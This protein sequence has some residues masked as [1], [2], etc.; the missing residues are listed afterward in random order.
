MYGKEVVNLDLDHIEEMDE[1]TGME[2]CRKCRSDKG[3]LYNG[4][5]PKKGK[6]KLIAMVDEEFSTKGVEI[7]KRLARKYNWH[8]IQLFGVIAQIYE[9]TEEEHYGV[10]DE[11]LLM[12]LDGEIKQTRDLFR[13]FPMYK[14]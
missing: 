1:L 3:R 13:H 12:V 6:Q 2:L 7:C 9:L 5:M 11:M 14:H 10:V 8:Q 4:K